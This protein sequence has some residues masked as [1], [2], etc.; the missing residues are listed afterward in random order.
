M[1]TIDSSLQEDVINSYMMTIDSSLQEDVINS[2][3]VLEISD[4]IVEA[5]RVRVRV[6]VSV[7]YPEP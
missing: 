3:G 4:E 6:R 2:R 7:R 1:M 5:V